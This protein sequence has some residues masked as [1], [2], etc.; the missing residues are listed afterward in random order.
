MTV[1]FQKLFFYNFLYFSK[2]I[3]FTNLF[4]KNLF[5]YNL[6]FLQIYFFFLQIYFFT[7]YVIHMLN[8][9]DGLIFYQRFTCYLAFLKAIN[10]IFA[11]K[12][13]LL[14]WVTYLY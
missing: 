11:E 8:E 3:F 4:L 10:V 14:I 9:I 7:I 6:H 5:F 2:F 1:K 12:Y 13:K